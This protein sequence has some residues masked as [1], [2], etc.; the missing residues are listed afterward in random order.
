MAL[1]FAECL[2]MKAE[3]ATFWAGWGV[4]ATGAVGLVTVLVAVLAWRTSRQAAKIAAN[5]HQDASALKRAQARVVGRLLLHEITALPEKLRYHIDTLEAVYTDTEKSVLRLRDLR[6]AVS[7][8]TEPLLPSAEASAEQIHYLPDWMGADLAT[9]I[10]HSRD[11]NAAARHISAHIHTRSHGGIQGMRATYSYTGRA[12]A[13]PALRGQLEFVASI[14][15]KFVKEFTEEVVRM[16][17]QETD[18]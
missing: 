6:S 14:A 16:R 8:L 4:L 9:M 15:P 2:S 7:A 10:S 5:Q 12:N 11:I 13:L 3:C 18:F 1:G 17:E